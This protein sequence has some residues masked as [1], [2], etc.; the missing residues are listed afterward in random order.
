MIRTV[1]VPNTQTVTFNVPQD[2]IGKELEV[3]A[4]TKN[5]GIEATELPKKEISFNAISVD[6]INFKFNRDEANER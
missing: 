4:F 5:E 6:T 3:I 1:I 2:Y